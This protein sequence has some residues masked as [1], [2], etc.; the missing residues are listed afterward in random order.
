[1]AETVWGR[2]GAVKLASL[3]L[4]LAFIV[5]TSRLTPGRTAWLECL[6]VFAVLFCWSSFSI[7]ANDLADRPV[8]AAAGKRRLLGQLPAGVGRAVVASLAVAGVLI[9]LW[10]GTTGGALA[11]Y[12]AA[13]LLAFLYSVKPFRLKARG[14]A[15]LLTYSL[16]CAVA[17]VAVPW[18]WLGAGWSVLAVL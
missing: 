16:S 12:S 9:M 7:L 14:W 17:Y 11:A 13:L 10:G 15:G 5:S 4:P 1:M 8:D 6:R 3:W 18:A 2:R